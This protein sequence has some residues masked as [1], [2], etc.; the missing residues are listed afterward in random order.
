MN[1]ACFKGI[2]F[3][4]AVK[5][6]KT[7]EQTSLTPI[8]STLNYISSYDIRETRDLIGWLCGIKDLIGSLCGTMDLIGWLCGTMDLIGLL[9]GTMDLIGWLCGTMDLIGLLCEFQA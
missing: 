3:L 5:R 9:C 2:Q 6:Q 8:S 4:L 7:E 1:S